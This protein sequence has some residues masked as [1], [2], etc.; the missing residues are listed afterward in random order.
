M[1][2]FKTEKHD[3]YAP[4]GDENK[5]SALGSYPNGDTMLIG[6][7]DGSV[8]FVDPETFKKKY[9]LEENSVTDFVSVEVGSW[10]GAA[11]KLINELEKL[12]LS[13]NQ[14]M[15]ISAYNN[16]PNENA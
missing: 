8:T 4:G 12:N 10:D 7:E 13:T 14:I 1:F 16:G 6:H 3:K 9:E 15:S 2:N 5:V 11:Y